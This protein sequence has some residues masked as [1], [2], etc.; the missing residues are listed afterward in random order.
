MLDKK[1]GV[2][3]KFGFWVKKFCVKKL[4]LK[5]NFGQ[6]AVLCSKEFGSKKIFLVRR[7]FLGIKDILGLKQILKQNNLWSNNFGSTKNVII[8]SMLGPKKLGS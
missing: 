3:K 4:F 7:V 8:R 1:N 5:K 2:K 6:K